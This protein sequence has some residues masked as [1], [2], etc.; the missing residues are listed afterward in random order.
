MLVRPYFE[1]PHDYWKPLYPQVTLPDRPHGAE[2]RA[3]HSGP[4]R[5]LD[6][7]S[8]GYQTFMDF[9]D[10]HAICYSWTVLWIIHDNTSIYQL[11]HELST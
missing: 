4:S 3:L 10:V 5:L 7:A 11:Y 1:Y 2:S 9:I 6:L 8:E